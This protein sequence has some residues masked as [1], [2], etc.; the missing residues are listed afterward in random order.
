MGA[1]RQDPLVVID[2]AGCD[3]VDSTF[4]GWLVGLNKLVQRAPGGCV[5]LSGCSDR[6][7]GSLERMQLTGLLH[8]ETADPP[9][10]TRAVACTTSDQPSK[11]EFKLMLQAHEQLASLSAENQR[12]F[13][14]IA[15]ALRTQAEKP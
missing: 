8:F 10:E 4:A 2:L 5:T 3:W 1:H 11:D 14:P 9:T 6:C 12:V 13:G 7:R 15:A